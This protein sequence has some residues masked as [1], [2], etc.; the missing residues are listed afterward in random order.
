MI[1]HASMI[2][3]AITCKASSEEKFCD[4]YAAYDLALCSG[5]LTQEELAKRWGWS[6]SKVSRKREILVM[7]AHGILADL[8]KSEYSQ[9]E[10]AYSI[11]QNGNKNA[12]FEKDLHN[13]D[14]DVHKSEYFDHEQEKEKE[15]KEKV[16]QK[17]KKEREKEPPP[18]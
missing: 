8:H 14:Q 11:G 4:R 10:R 16:T 12:V 3:D 2:R 17:E 1:D 13:S 7:A 5:N 15:Q 9:E 6:Q 18:P